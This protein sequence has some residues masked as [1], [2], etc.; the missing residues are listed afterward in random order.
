MRKSHDTHNRTSFAAALGLLARR[1]GAL[2]YDALIVM[3]GLMIMTFPYLGILVWLTDQTSPDPGDPIYQLYILILLFGYVWFSWRRGGQ[4]IGMKAWRL[5]A[6]SQDGTTLSHQQIA[7][8]FALAFPSLLL[9]G[10]GLWWSLF[11]PQQ[12]T[13]HEQFSKS[14]TR[15]RAKANTLGL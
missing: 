11:H 9:C 14:Q 7:L 13:A 5:Q 8:R 6:L 10:L 2:S 4:T 1:L 3:G 15:L 12:L